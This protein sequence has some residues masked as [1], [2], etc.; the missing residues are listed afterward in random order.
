MTACSLFVAVLMNGYKKYQQNGGSKG[1]NQN[2]CGHEKKGED[3][4]SQGEQRDPNIND[5][6]KQATLPVSHSLNTNGDQLPDSKDNDI[7]CRCTQNNKATSLTHIGSQII[8]R[9]DKSTRS[10]SGSKLVPT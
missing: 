5:M 6:E 3:G 1:D 7:C 4:D 2:E 8:H 10:S 9:G